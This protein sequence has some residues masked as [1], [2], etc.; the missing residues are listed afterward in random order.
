MLTATGPPTCRTLWTSLLES[1]RLGV[2]TLTFEPSLTLHVNVPLPGSAF[3]RC[4]MS[5]YDSAQFW[6][7]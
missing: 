1:G 4:G 2:H 6:R 7:N 3:M 5:L